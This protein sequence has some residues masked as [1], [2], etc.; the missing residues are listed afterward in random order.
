MAS[1]QIIGGSQT[2]QFLWNTVNTVYLGFLRGVGGSSLEGKVASVQILSE[3]QKKSFLKATAT[4]LAGAAI[5]GPIGAVAGI[6][7]GGNRKEILFSCELHDGGQ[8][9]AKGDKRI[10]ELLLAESMKPRKADPPAVS[11]HLT[12]EQEARAKRANLILLVV[13]LIIGGMTFLFHAPI[14]EFLSASP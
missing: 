9:I 10:F 8:F 12:P 5:A 7:A 2:G 6:V 11:Y 13:L 3:E 14:T 4:G 1:A